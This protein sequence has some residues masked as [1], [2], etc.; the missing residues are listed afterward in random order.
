MVSHIGKLDGG[1][2]YQW[3]ALAANAE[4]P[5]YAVPGRAG[6]RG[7]TPAIRCVADIDPK[8]RHFLDTTKTIFLYPSA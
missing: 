7:S 5:P 2:N 6:G 1:G 8:V 4:I 3:E